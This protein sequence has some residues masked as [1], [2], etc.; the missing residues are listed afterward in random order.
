MYQY[1]RGQYS[2]KKSLYILWEGRKQDHRAH[3]V[4]EYLPERY[5]VLRNFCHSPV[6][7]L[8]NISQKRFTNSQEQ[9]AV[10]M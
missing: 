7:M 10:A 4:R 9:M 3:E 6:R 8:S 5:E 2:Y 1:K